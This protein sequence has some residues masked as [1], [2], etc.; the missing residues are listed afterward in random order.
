MPERRPTARQKRAAAERAG[1]RCEYC[2]CPA[3]YSSDPFAAEHIR[4]R[5]AGGTH[6]LSNL[7]FSCLGCNNFKYT[8]MEA[9][10]PMTGET[11]PLYHPRRDGWRDHFTWNEEYTEIVGLTATGRATVDR[12]QLNRPGVINLRRVLR[13]AGEHPPL[14]TIEAQ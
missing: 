6:E 9:I 13:L 12:L 14:A 4:P 11:V 10:D 2:L 8:S 3:D 1:R 7:A 5:V